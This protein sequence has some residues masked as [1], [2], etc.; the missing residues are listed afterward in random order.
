MVVQTS[1]FYNFRQPFFLSYL[2]CRIKHIP[3]A[4]FPRKYIICPPFSA[5]MHIWR[6]MQRKMVQTLL[7]KGDK[8]LNVTLDHR[9]QAD[10][11]PL[12]SEI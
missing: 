1:K 9:L 3:I 10:C 11:F 4:L 2:G 12:Q 8:G 7:L 6:Q 5:V